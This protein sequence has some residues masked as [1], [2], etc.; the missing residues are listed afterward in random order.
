GLANDR[1]PG[2]GRRQPPRGPHRHRFT[3]SLG[4][5]SQVPV[6]ELRVITMGVEERMGPVRL[7]DVGFWDWRCQQPVVG[8]AGELQYPTRHRHGDPV[9]GELSYERVGTIDQQ[10]SP[11]TDTPRPDAELRSPAQADDCADA[12]LVVRRTRC[13]FGGGNVCRFGQTIGD[14]CFVD[15]GGPGRLGCCCFFVANQKHTDTSWEIFQV[16]LWRGGY[17]YR[18]TFGQARSDVTQPLHSPLLPIE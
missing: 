2:I 15:A 3:G 1:E 4:L 16:G 8:L 9:G 17:T 18:L 7:G 11:A 13:W 14:G 12:S 5:I 6:P 10:A